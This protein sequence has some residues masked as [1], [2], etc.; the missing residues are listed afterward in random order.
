[1]LQIVVPL[2]ITINEH[3]VK[4]PLQT[5]S[6]YKTMIPASFSGWVR[7]KEAHFGIKVPHIYL[8][9]AHFKLIVLIMSQLPI[10]RASQWPTTQRHDPYP[11]SEALKLRLSP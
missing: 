6:E 1:M 5:S 3:C 9:R 8:D 4:S 2:P 11:H 10:K 7:V